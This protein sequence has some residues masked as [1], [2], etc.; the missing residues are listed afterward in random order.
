LNEGVPVFG[1]VL[2]YALFDG[3]HIRFGLVG[4]WFV[5]V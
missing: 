4:G 3:C 5:Q 1:L 2:F